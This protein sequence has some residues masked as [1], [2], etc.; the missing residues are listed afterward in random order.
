M[1]KQAA[2]QLAAKATAGTC[3]ADSCRWLSLHL[4][5]NQPI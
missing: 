3:A 2:L 5:T 1:S 4:E